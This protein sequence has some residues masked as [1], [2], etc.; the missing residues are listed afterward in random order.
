MILSAQSIR[1]LCH[2]TPPLIKPFVPRG[3]VN[4]KSYGLSSCS[5]DCRISHDLALGP[6][7]SALA[8]TME[9]FCFPY[10]ICGQILDKSSWARRFVTAFNT[11]FD[12]GFEGFA[13]IELVNLGREIVS[14]AEGD[15]LCQMIFYWLDEPTERPYAGKYQNQ[16]AGPVAARH[17]QI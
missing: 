15:P 13:T 16:E 9:R 5:Y 8:A 6:G 10:N 12:P 1:K 4:G 14:F 2:E 11:H 17:E 3:I 7:A